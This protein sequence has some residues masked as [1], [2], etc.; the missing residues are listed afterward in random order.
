MDK[1][2]YILEN[3]D[4]AHCASKME[5]RIND[6]PGVTQAAISF[7]TKQLQLTAEHPDELLPQI[8]KICTSLE[9][10]VKIIPKTNDSDREEKEK[11]ISHFSLFWP[12]PYFLSDSKLLIPSA[13]QNPFPFR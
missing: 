9:P 8:R 4:C 6:L 13:E 2:I 1:K 10:E 3:L 5:A 7:P 12:E 11:S